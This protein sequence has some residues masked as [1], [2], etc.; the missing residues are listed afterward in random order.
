[1]GFR[2]NH[3]GQCVAKEFGDGHIIR[4]QI[5]TLGASPN[6]SSAPDLWVVELLTHSDLLWLTH[7]HIYTRIHTHSTRL[8]FGSSGY[9]ERLYYLKLNE[10]IHTHTQTNST[11][12]SHHCYVLDYT[13]SAF[14][15]TLHL[16]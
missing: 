14:I 16:C 15:I 12:V 2:I 10:G 8:S 9:Y 3:L 5:H 1:M 7:A 4:V 13:S 6:G 11:A